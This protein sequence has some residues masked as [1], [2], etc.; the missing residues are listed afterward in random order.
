MPHSLVRR[1]DHAWRPASR[2]WLVA[3]GALLLFGTGPLAAQDAAPAESPTEPAATAP[4]GNEDQAT[5]SAEPGPTES[6][7]APPAAA[8]ATPAAEPAAPLAP[9]AAPAGDGHA[10]EHHGDAAHGADEHAGGHEHLTGLPLWS[11]IPFGLLLLSIAAFPLVNPHW[12]EHNSS[13]GLIAGI[14][15]VPMAGFVLSYGAAGQQQL[16]HTGMEYISFLLLLG[17]LFLISGGIYIR[18][19]FAGGPMVNSMFLAFGALIA[20]FV[21]TTGASMLLIRPLLRANEHRS[22]VAHIVVFFIFI[23][24]NCGGLL[25]PLGDPPLFLGFLKGVPFLWTMQLWREWLT[26]NAILLV[27]FYIYDSLSL[28]NDQDVRPLPETVE[29]FGLQGSHN[30]LFLLGIVAVIYCSGQ[31]IGNGGQP[32]AFGVA[33]GL[34][35]VLG[36]VSYLLTNPQIRAQNRFTFAPII[37][38]AVLFAGIFTTMIP[39]LVLLNENGKNLGLS[40]GWHFFWATGFLSSFLDNAP[41][42]L[43]FAAAACG[44]AGIETTGSYLAEFLKT[45]GANKTLAAIA[46]G[47]V[48]MGANTYIGNGP[49]FMVKAIAEENNVRMPGFFAYMGYSGAILIPTFVVITLLFFR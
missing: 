28:K 43:A 31:G 10:N 4:A 20:S 38:V 45:P 37:E 35:A 17:S 47:A 26:V 42:Y 5:P 18:G 30:L 32:W 39:A 11:V 24:S 22:R 19:T 2:Q 1:P 40:E 9:A 12:W 29:P 49:N 21:G 34:M 14:L 16:Q 13:K 7:T 46:C 8:N 44:N 33:E 41:T 48:F 3:F 15:G 6:T 27:V 25:T 23:V 36:V